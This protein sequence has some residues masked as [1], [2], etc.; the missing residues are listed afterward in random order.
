[1]LRIS[2]LFLGLGVLL[3]SGLAQAQGTGSIRVQVNGH[4]DVHGTSPTTPP[5]KAEVKNLRNG[6]SQT[7][8]ISS[9]GRANVD[10]LPDGTYQVTVRTG[11]R[12]G[13]TYVTISGGKSVDALLSAHGL[14]TGETV[15]AAPDALLAAIRSAID[16]CDRAA[17]DRAVAEL[18]RNISMLEINLRDLDRA[19]GEYGN[20]T[21][22]QPNIGQLQAAL[23]AV[24]RAYRA[25]V[26]RPDP[27]LEHVPAYIAALKEK[28]RIEARLAALRAAR[29]QVPPFP[30]PCDKRVGFLGSDKG[31]FGLS[32]GAGVASMDFPNYKAYAIE[33]GM[34]IQQAD[35]FK[36]DR[37]R[38]VYDVGGEGFF[39]IPGTDTRLRFSGSAR[40][41]DSNANSDFEFVPGMGERFNVPSPDGGFFTTSPVD[42]FRISQKMEQ[43]E[44]GIQAEQAFT[45]GGTVIR[46]RIGLAF[47]YIDAADS[48]QFNIAGGFAHFQEWRS[49]DTY[50]FGP[51]LG[52]EV[53]VPLYRGLYG[54][55]AVGGELRWNSSKGRWKTEIDVMGTATTQVDRQSD[56]KM[57]WGINGSLGLGYR[58]GAIDLRAGGTIGVSNHYPTLDIQS[59]VADGSPT[60]AWETTSREAAWIRATFTF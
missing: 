16:A 31:R 36:S 14:P 6:E 26:L 9:G 13:T 15:A 49:L 5:G 48:S 47:S 11:D 42:E 45:A 17:Y 37:R 2:M 29:A 4:R 46:P 23:D 38:T 27:G 59:D 60:I 24:P 57:T 19:I 22:R 41:F 52:V 25:G 7:T 40:R 50:G 53:E 12:I 32:F 3:T 8:D 34:I 10:G 35:V 18:E 54:F 33:A 1:M 55:G 51:T 44:I 21:G 56:N 28:A 30:E 58:T 43:Y 39:Y 20:L